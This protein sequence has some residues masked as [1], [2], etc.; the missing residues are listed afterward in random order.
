MNR[1]ILLTVL[2]LCLLAASVSAQRDILKL[3]NGKTQRVN[4]SAMSAIDLTHKGGVI[5]RE[6]ILSV[7]F[8]SGK[9]LAIKEYKR[10]LQAEADEDFGTAIELYLAAAKKAAT[11]NSVKDFAPQFFCWR[12]YTLAKENGFGVADLRDILTELRATR[13]DHFYLP[14]LWRL[15]I[16]QSWNNDGSRA[17]LQKAK[18][19]VLAFKADV[20]KKGLSERYLLEAELYLVLAGQ[21]LK[22]IKPSAAEVSLNK[23]VNRSKGKYPDLVN[24][25]ILEV[26]NSVLRANKFEE[27]RKRFDEIIESSAADDATLAGAYL[28]RGHTRFLSGTRSP[29]QAK[30][31][32]KDYM[33]VAVLFPDTDIEIVGEALWHARDA[34]RIWNGANA[35]QNRRL[36]LVK[37][38]TKYRDS[39]WAKK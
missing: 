38:K 15:R 12:A 29:Q 9:I 7:E 22:E 10:A 1:R 31:A 14:D 6:Q 3:S 23:L 5:P 8:N 39:S 25:L 37:L 36:L 16:R 21:R 32:L 24:R 33:R 26:A 2:P 18:N 28:G 34:Y 17:A 27:A 4:V 20:E 11:R 13:A 19:T 35:V 30:L